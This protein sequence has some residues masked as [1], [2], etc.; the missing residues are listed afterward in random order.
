MT[1]MFSICKAES[2]IPSFQ[3]EHETSEGLH[4]FPYFFADIA[5]TFLVAGNDDY[6]IIPRHAS[7]NT[8][9]IDRVHT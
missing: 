2:I 1:A 6:R 9:Q 3:I 5:R 8:R 7:E 4:Q